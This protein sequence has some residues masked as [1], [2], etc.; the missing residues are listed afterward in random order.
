MLPLCGLST[1]SAILSP[2]S[3]LYK[4][5]LKS[6]PTLTKWFPSGAYL[7]SCTNLVCSR[8][9]CR[10][11]IQYISSPSRLSKQSMSTYLDVLEW[12]SLEMTPQA[13]K[14]E[15]DKQTYPDGN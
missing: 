4:T 6:D 2:F 10:R 9:V 13:K 12:G 3:P 8:I 15:M 11:V 5:I 14:L 7:T 1:T